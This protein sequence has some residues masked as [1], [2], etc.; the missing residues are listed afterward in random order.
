[1][2]P[3][4]GEVHP[5]LGQAAAR[6][7]AEHDARVLGV[8][9]A[10]PV[11]I[12]VAAAVTGHVRHAVVEPLEDG[13]QAVGPVGDAVDAGLPVAA[14]DLLGRQSPGRQAMLVVPFELVEVFPLGVVGRAE[15]SRLHEGLHQ[16]VLP[17]VGVVFAH[18]VY[19]AGGPG[20][21]DD[22]PALLD[23]NRRR[24][25]AEYVQPPVQRGDGLW[26]VERHGRGDDHAV[27][28]GPLEHFIVVGVLFRGAQQLRG[29]GQRAG[30]DVA[31]GVD[32][33]LRQ[34]VAGG[35]EA[36]APAAC[37]GDAEVELFT[38]VVHVNSPAWRS[39]ACTPPGRSPARRAGPGGRRF[40]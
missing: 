30:V 15:M 8:G 11:Q 17:D 34:G 24:D 38:G 32:A 12:V 26:R 35:A 7:L 36:L 3:V 20:R 37:P 10:L 18:H 4:G 28:V 21:P 2:G 29:G 6:H 39:A 27:K 23:R 16:H 13:P 14:P 1:M 22:P 40:R 9:P 5:D 33:D 31:H 19:A 25:L